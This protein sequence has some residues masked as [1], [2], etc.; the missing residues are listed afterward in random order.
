MKKRKLV[1]GV[2]INDVDYIVNVWEGTEE[3]YPSGNKKQVLVWA[4]PY[5][6]R[7]VSMIQRCYSK[8]LQ[9]EYPTY[10]GCIVCVDWLTFSNF[11]KW[12]VTQ[13][14]EGRELDK[15]LLK[16]GNRIYSPEN[17]VFVTKKVNI[18]A[19]NRG[20]A[21]GKYLIGCCWNK[22]NKKF[23]SRCCNPFTKKQEYLGYF[24]TEIEAHLAWKK[25]KHI[26]SCELADSGYVTDERVRQVLLHRYENYTVVEDHLKIEEI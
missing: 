14:W 3:R 8:K 11:R 5:Y 19:V 7:W 20:N 18:F 21:R 9:E 23:Q 4:C 15:D 6:S 10:K 16:D 12:M 17:C 22:Q 13:D 1:C 26:Y 2:G 24:D 25:Q